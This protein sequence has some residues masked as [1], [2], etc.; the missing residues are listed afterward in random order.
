MIERE[1]APRLAYLFKRHPFVTVTGPRYA[2][3]TILCRT[4]FPELEYIDLEM[5]NHRDFAEADPWRFLC[6]LENGAILDEAQRAPELFPYLQTVADKR[7][8][9]SLFILIGSEQSGFS[10]VFGQSPAGRTA[11]L[12]LLPLSL[13]E[14]HQMNTNDNI[15]DILFSGFFP[16][17]HA[18]LNETERALAKYLE[19]YIER[20][21]RRIGGI[22]DLSNFRRFIRLCAGRIGH[23]VNHTALGTDAGISHTTARYWL[24][25]LEEIYV[26]YFLP[27]YF[28]NNRRRLIKSPK[29]Y[30]YDTGLASHL[31]GIEHASQVETHPLRGAL[32]ENA[33]VTEVMKYQCNTGQKSNLFF[34]RDARGL[35]CHLLYAIK[36]GVGTIT[37]RPGATITADCFRHLDRISE[38]I[39]NVLVKAVIYGGSNRQSHEK[40]E[41]VPFARVYEFIENLH[42]A[43]QFSVINSRCTKSI[44]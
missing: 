31:L 37:I 42:K 14:R 25:I 35:E 8:Q 43:N 1:I 12:S 32:F 33:V 22:R 17:V 20:D 28:V 19:T 40:G 10:K 7:N 2:G 18:R 3:K 5:P 27:P 38:A 15:D 41:I 34:Y 26:V 11:S 9:D 36:N 39:P 23:T 13:S 24:D 29:L 6:R 16:S 21:A 4:T 30:F 44:Y